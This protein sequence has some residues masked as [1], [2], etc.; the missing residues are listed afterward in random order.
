MNAPHGL[1][2]DRSGDVF[3]TGYYGPTQKFNGYGDF[4]TAF[5][6]GMP[7]DGPSYFHSVGGDKW[8]NA[9]V[10]VRNKGGY[11]GAVQHGDEGYYSVMK[12]N[13][14]GDFI[15]G[16]AYSAADHSESEVAVA[17]DGRVFC[18]FNGR[19]ESG[20]ETFAQE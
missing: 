12:Y 1:F 13:N 20:V 6:H 11:D 14:N 4:V 15:C 19:E 17:E 10:S 5:A 7:P 3:I 18:L 8:G 2:V 9:Y 16:W